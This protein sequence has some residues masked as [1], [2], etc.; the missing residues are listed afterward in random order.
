MTPLSSFYCLPG[1]VDLTG[2]ENRSGNLNP[3]P[4]ELTQQTAGLGG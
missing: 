3:G 1:V 2:V 4:S